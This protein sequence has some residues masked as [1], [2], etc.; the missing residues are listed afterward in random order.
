[1]VIGVGGMWTASIKQVAEC[2]TGTKYGIIDVTAEVISDRTKRM[3]ACSNSRSVRYVL[4][5]ECK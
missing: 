3:H 4:F 2:N 1:M 5:R